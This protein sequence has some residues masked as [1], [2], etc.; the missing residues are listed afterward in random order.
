MHI[1]PSLEISIQRKERLIKE[2]FY[3]EDSGLFGFFTGTNKNQKHKLKMD[4]LKN[5]TKTQRMDFEEL[6]K[7]KMFDKAGIDFHSNN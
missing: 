2:V 6:T 7:Q 4:D 1:H 3:E 5:L